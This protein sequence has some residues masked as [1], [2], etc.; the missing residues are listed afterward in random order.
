MDVHRAW[1]HEAFAAPDD[2]EQLLARKDS[3][4]GAHQGR[5]ELEFLAG[6]LDQAALHPDLEAVAIDLDVTR[7]EMML[8]LLHV[9]L[10][11]GDGPDARDQLPGRKRL[12]HVVVGAQREPQDLVAF[13]DPARHHDHGDRGELRVLLEP[14]AHFPSVELGH[15]DIEEDHVGAGVAGETERV[16]AVAGDHDVVALFGQLISHQLRNVLLVLEQEDPTRAPWRRR[17]FAAAAARGHRRHLPRDT[18]AAECR[19]AALRDDDGRVNLG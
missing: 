4:R 19:P 18:H 10:P 2:V 14:A 7:L 3:A 6:E 15:H 5:Q 9:G 1:L 17:R 11:A 8:L 13:L 12:G 16:G